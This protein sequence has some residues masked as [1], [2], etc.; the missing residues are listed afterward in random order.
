MEV[1]AK[2]TNKSIADN[3]FALPIITPTIGILNWMKDDIKSLDLAMR[4][5][6]TMNGAFHQSSDVNRLYVKRAEGDCGLKNIKDMYEC[7]TISLLEHLEEAGDTHGLLKLLGEH[8]GQGTVRLGNE[9]RERIKEI[10]ESSNFIEGTKKIHK[11]EWK[12]EWL[13]NVTHGYHQT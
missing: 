10:S 3:S 12:R 7:R 5:L 11:R 4:K 2:C 13:K 8:E 6:L 1:R 9:F